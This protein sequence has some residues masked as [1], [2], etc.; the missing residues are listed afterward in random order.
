MLRKVV[1]TLAFL[2]A[3]CTAHA[4]SPPVI[5]LGDSIGEGVQSADANASTQPN[6][7]LAL[8]AG[9]MGEPFTLPLIRTSPLGVVGSTTGRSRI[10]PTARVAN[11]AVS[12][13]SSGSILTDSAGFPVDEEI[14]LVEMPRT[15]TQIEI[16]QRLRSPLVICWIGNNDVLGSALA[17]DHMDASQI[18]PQDVFADNYQQIVDGLTGW[19]DKVVFANIPDITRIGFL[20]S[21]DD[22]KLFIGDSYGLPQ[23]SYTSLVAMLMIRMG[24]LPPTILHDPS[25]VLDANEIATIRNAIGGFNRTIATDAAAADM[26]VVDIHS[27]MNRL[28]A[29]PPMIGGVPL[30]PRYNGGLLSLDGVHPSDIGHALIANAF[31]AK[32]DATWQMGIPPLSQDQ[33][34][35]IALKDPFVDFNG[36]LI[37]RGR[38]LRGLLET[39]GPALGI[40]GD[41]PLQPG[42][43]AE[44]GGQF[45]REYFAAT[46]QNPARAWTQQ[47]AIAAMRHVFGLDAHAKSG[48]T[49]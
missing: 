17:F 44:L 39:L 14:D 4:E 45:M 40:S 47:D 46:G 22:L 28:A 6:T 42:I 8:M 25:W 2:A 20:F 29:H 38:P 23:G 21:P 7:Y 37:V 41:R 5:G 27:I 11:L 16:A 19:N 9:Q 36:N 30:L 31:I 34:A 12:G 43:Q 13:A 18:T 35:S 3:A 33:L 26:P 1:A 49:H 10:D 48:T 24:L 15:G 32:M